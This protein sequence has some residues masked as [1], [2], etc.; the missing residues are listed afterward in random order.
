MHS[1]PV[2]SPAF[3]PFP[4]FSV[5]IAVKQHHLTS[6]VH[7]RHTSCVF[8]A[9]HLHACTTMLQW[10]PS[11]LVRVSA[12]PPS[13]PGYAWAT[14]CLRLGGYA[15]QPRPLMIFSHVALP[16]LQYT[17][18]VSFACNHPSMLDPRPTAHVTRFNLT[19]RIMPKICR[20]TTGTSWFVYAS[21]CPQSSMVAVHGQG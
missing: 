16:A 19:H 4:S 5:H 10:Q 2:A 21:K 13:C 15:L 18:H 6:T 20:C 17:L 9:R 7:N 1:L 12:L 3:T 14:C 8:K 11:W